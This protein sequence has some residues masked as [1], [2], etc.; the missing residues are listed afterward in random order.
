MNSKSGERGTLF[1][2][3]AV[4]FLARPKFFWQKARQG[5]VSIEFPESA[6]SGSDSDIESE[7]DS[8]CFEDGHGTEN[9]GSAESRLEENSYL[10]A[11]QH[12]RNT[13]WRRSGRTAWSQLEGDARP[14]SFIMPD[15]RVVSVKL[16]KDHYAWRDFDV[17]VVGNFPYFLQ[18]Y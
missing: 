4:V 13:V 3:K 1:R 8:D 10:K 17:A 9:A 7:S 18:I 14:G 11:A 15:E 2:I 16:V 5:L 12:P 6:S